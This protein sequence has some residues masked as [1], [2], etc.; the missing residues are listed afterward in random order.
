MIRRPIRLEGGVLV[1]TESR[2]LAASK[3]GDQ[4]VGPNAWV[5]VTNWTVLNQGAA[6]LNPGTGEIAVGRDG[7]YR[8]EVWLRLGSGFGPGGGGFGP[9]GRGFIRALATS[10]PPIPLIRTTVTL[11]DSTPGGFFGSSNNVLALLPTPISLTAGQTFVIQVQRPG[12]GSR[13]I[14]ASGSG[15]SLTGPD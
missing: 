10:G 2:L 8:L 14:L 3:D 7:F 1:E 12:I 15:M 5:T 6:T 4:S 11:E 9:G 13:D